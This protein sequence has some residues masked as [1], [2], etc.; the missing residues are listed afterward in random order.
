MVVKGLKKFKKVLYHFNSKYLDCKVRKS[1]YS[2]NKS[3]IDMEEFYEK[4]SEFCFHGIIERYGLGY[5]KL[6][7]FIRSRLV[8][9]LDIRESEKKVRVGI[10][11][12]IR[13]KDCLFL[14]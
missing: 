4:L 6:S 7:A 14:L 2:F 3:D 8:L 9:D 10:Y 12:R 11:T 1:I 13:K 5:F